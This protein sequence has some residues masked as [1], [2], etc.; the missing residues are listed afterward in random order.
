MSKPREEEEEDQTLIDAE[1]KR[2][3]ETDST[4]PL[5]LLSLLISN[6]EPRNQNFL[7]LISLFFSH[8]TDF[9]KSDLTSLADLILSHLSQIRDIDDAQLLDL[10]PRCLTLILESN[11]IDRND[12][13]VDSALDRLITSDWSKGLLLK[14]VSIMR[15]FSFVDKIRAGELLKK[16]FSGLSRVDLQDLPSIVYQLLVSASKGFG[17]REVIEG[18]LRFFGDKIGVKMKVNSSIV[19]QVEGTVLLHVNFSVKQDPSLGQ[20]VLGL[21]K[22]D[23]R[24]FNH[25]TVV[26]LLSLA[27][28]RRFSESSMGILKMAVLNAYQ[29][30]KFAKGC[31]WLPG[32]LQEEYIQNAKLIE[33]AILRA[34]NESNYGK[35]HILPSVVKYGFTLLESV[36]EDKPKEL[37][38]SDGLRGIEGLGIQMLKALYEVQDMARNESTFNLTDI[39]CV[40]MGIYLQ[41]D[42]KIAGISVLSL[43]MKSAS[44]AYSNSFEIIEQCKFRILSLKPEKSTVI[45]KLIGHLIQSYPFPML[46]HVSRL[47]EL[48]DYFTFMHYKTASTLVTAILPLIKFSCDLQDYTIL[49]VRKAM[50][51]R[52]D[53]VRLA[54]I[55]AIISLILVDMQLKSSDPNP[56]QDST[57]QA[58]CSQQA[59]IPCNKGVGLF[60]ELGGLLQR[61]LYQQGKVKEV[62]YNGLV[63]LVLVDPSVAGP[64]FDFLWPHFLRFYKEE[65]DAQLDISCCVKSDSGKIC[66]QEPLDC[67]LSCVSWILLFQTQGKT[68]CPQNSSGA[69]FGFSLSQDNESGRVYSGESFSTAIAK[70]RKLLRKGK[71]EGS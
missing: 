26:V 24:V 59:D 15:D 44:Q 63:K 57:S 38:I 55:N 17:K 48:L 7:K 53:T 60:H 6:K 68:G 20:E 62:L 49:V 10:L 45:I 61:C 18:V 16:V 11:D 39:S 54:A 12:D 27:R 31:K 70:I 4:P 50:F 42:G 8:L 58:S 37:K 21:V 2:L 32:E 1:I 66:V 40:R 36:E 69:C 28:V 25:F 65:A 51:G 33:K 35:E 5:S 30:Y 46:E 67:L 47:K 29:D 3:A 43:C 52:E 22:S 9:P 56:F 71:L 34:V 13:F 19:R 64:I 41:M 23:L 14:M